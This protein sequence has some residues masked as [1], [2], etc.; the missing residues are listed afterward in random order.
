MEKYKVK[1]KTETI[2]C[3]SYDNMIAIFFYLRKLGIPC[4]AIIN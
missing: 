4:L 1:T 2:K 3:F